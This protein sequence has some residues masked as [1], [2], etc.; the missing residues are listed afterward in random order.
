MNKVIWFFSILFFLVLPGFSQETRQDT[1]VQQSPDMRFEF[2]DDE[3][4]PVPKR[5]RQTSPAYRFSTN[6]I[7]TVQ[8]NVNEN[9]ENILG[10]AANEPSIAVDPTD[11][12]KMAIGWRQFDTIESNFRQAGWGYTTDSGQNWTFPGVI[13]PG[14]FRS[15]PVLD[16]D[17]EGNFFYNSLYHDMADEFVCDVFKSTDGGATWDAG[18]F[19]QG[20]DKQWMAIDRTTGIGRGNIYAYWV[21]YF[22][23]CSP[24]NF[25]RST[26]AGL[27]FED[28]SHI[29]QNPYYG[30]LT[31]GNDGELYVCGASDGN[32][33]VLKSTNAQ[34]PSQRVTWDLS[35]TVSLGGE[36]AFGGGPNPDGLLG[37]AWIAVD[38]S[39]GPTRGNVYLL[40]SV[41]PYQSDDP[42]DVMFSR[43]TDGG[44]TWSPPVRVND[45]PGR[46]TWQWFG[47]MSVAPDSR[48]DVVWLDTRDSGNFHSS[49]YYA[50]STDAGVT[51]SWNKRLSESFDPH[52]GWPQQDKLGDYFHMISD[53]AGADLAW[54]ATFNGEQNIYYS[55]IP[56]QEN[57]NPPE[58]VSRYP[59]N[60]I[61]IVSGDSLE[62]SVE[63]VDP[64]GNPLRFQWHVNGAID[65]AGIYPSYMYRT[66]RSY[67][68]IDFFE[69]VVS[70]GIH[71]ITTQWTISTI[72]F[73][74]TFPTILI[75]ETHDQEFSTREWRAIELA[76]TWFGADYSDY[77]KDLFLCDELTDKL[78]KDYTVISDTT[79]PL[80]SQT[81]QHIDVLFLFP[82]RDDL[83]VEERSAIE[84][85]VSQGGHLLIL[86]M[87]Y[88]WFSGY[89][90]IANDAPYGNLYQLLDEL[91]F[92]ANIPTLCS[93]DDT[94][95]HKCYFEIDLTGE[96]PAT[97]HESRTYIFFGHKLETTKEY[98]QL[99]ETT[100]SMRVW[101]DTNNNWTK[102]D[103]E[104]FQSEVGIVGVS[105]YGL[106]RVVYM[107][108]AS[109]S[110]LFPSN[111]DIILSIMGWQTESLNSNF[112]ISDDN[113]DFGQVQKGTTAQWELTIFN[114]GIADVTFSNIGLDNSEFTVDTENLFVPE[115][116][117]VTLTVTYEPTDVGSDVATL[118]A[119]TDDLYT[120]DIS[121]LLTGEGVHFDADNDGVLDSE[122]NCPDDSNPLQEDND[123]D[124]YG[125]VCDNCPCIAN[126]DQTDSDGDGMGDVCAHLV[127]DI[128]GNCTTNILDVLRGV[129]MILQV[130]SPTEYEIAAGDCNG[131]EIFNILDVLGI[132]NVILGIGECPSV[133]GK[134]IITD[135]V[136]AFLKILE[137]YLPMED[138]NRF[139]KMVKAFLMVPEEYSLRQNYPNPFNPVTEITFSLPERT[140]V[141][142]KV[143]NILGQ[144]EDVLVEEE[145][146]AGKHTIKWDGSSAA[147]GIYFYRIEAN[148]FTSTKRMVLMK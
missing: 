98:S 120:P 56:L 119:D 9:G 31:V 82:F 128:D 135:K 94:L 127:G 109:V 48:I 27:S 7:F 144:V 84:E 136:M 13:E 10:D 15:D 49:L 142:L 25:T 21:G 111:Q 139:M 108:T 5:D 54:A 42:L 19:A 35:T 75:D 32:F 140:D 38:H 44:A 23:V 16:Y 55:R 17:A 114:R 102:D 93:L 148:D 125:D 74:H 47:T 90:G 51:W 36:I 70:D 104:P 85:Y 143:Y 68:G 88:A 2:L 78:S 11:R 28:C 50:F 71:Q 131:D 41:K 22:S 81:L 37:Q 24:G 58:I 60:D 123:S 26:N 73:P 134:P 46:D 20:G 115:G 112:I 92:R 100:G 14:V 116:K 45:D 89:W 3:Y 87:G 43:S 6:E 67:S 1:L 133:A 117:N 8:V 30:T 113:Y 110:N 91:G 79:E 130:H 77:W 33:I 105:E 141:K 39:S 146:R 101:E 121:V 62:L 106:G 103:D 96:H 72:Q 126:P 12:T 137:E 83:S 53:S 107:S 124:G 61:T 65:S 64:D 52:V 138:F 34:D 147:S 29:E 118:T 63:A 99:I 4:I 86:G 76:T 69:V 57:K 59:Q 122:D 145:L 40:C 18:T 95:T 80:T 97:S 129:N 66:E 132:V